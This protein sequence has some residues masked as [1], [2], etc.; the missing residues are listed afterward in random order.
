MHPIPF[1][2]LALE[3]G[4]LSSPLIIKFP[5]FS[6]F[7]FLVSDLCPQV[8]TLRNNQRSTCWYHKFKHECES[9]T[10]CHFDLCSPFLYTTFQNSLGFCLVYSTICSIPTQKWYSEICKNLN[11][12][13]SFQEH[14]DCHTSLTARFYLLLPDKLLSRSVHRARELA[15]EYGTCLA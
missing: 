11:S 1:E 5:C 4:V 3:R 8:F 12:F 6:C 9:L 14:M 15:Q 2:A 7:V 10:D 13:P